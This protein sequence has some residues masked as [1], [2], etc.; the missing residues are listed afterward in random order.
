M[1][2]LHPEGPTE[3]IATVRSIEQVINEVGPTL[4]AVDNFFVAARDALS[5][6]KQ[7]HVLL[8]PNTL[9]DLAG[10][11]QGSGVFLWPV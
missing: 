5:A 2:I 8:S 3:Y 11:D 6:K 4:V 7:P 9:K 1:I 10:A